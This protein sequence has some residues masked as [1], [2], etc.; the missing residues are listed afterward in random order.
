MDA[1]FFTPTRDPRCVLSPMLTFLLQISLKSLCTIGNTT[2]Q[3]V[4]CVWQCELWHF[5]LTALG[6]TKCHLA[7]GSPGEIW[8]PHTCYLNP[9][10]W[11]CFTYC[12]YVPGRQLAVV[13]LQ[14]S[15]PV[16]VLVGVQT[17]PCARLHQ[18]RTALPLQSRLTENGCQGML[19]YM[20]II[21]MCI[22]SRACL[23]SM[24]MC[25]CTCMC[26]LQTL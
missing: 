19:L 7:N 22:S 6:V 24:C 9:E 21:H 13:L 12:A 5:F 26:V 11:H 25:M 17:S 18:L 23:H 4:C 15:S 10:P 20:H 8:L 2:R 3:S 14:T 16:P 1:W